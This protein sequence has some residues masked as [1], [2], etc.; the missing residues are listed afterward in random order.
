MNSHLS[1]G[2]L[3][4]LLAWCVLSVGLFSASFPANAGNI[5]LSSAVSVAPAWVV[6]T[7]GYDTATVVFA[8]FNDAG[9]TRTLTGINWSYELYGSIQVNIV[10]TWGDT[11]FSISSQEVGFSIMRPAT[12]SDVSATVHMG[13]ATTYPSDLNLSCADGNSCS[14]ANLIT[15]VGGGSTS[16]LSDLTFLA[17]GPQM[18]FDWY[19]GTWLNNDPDWAGAG[20]DAS[21]FGTASIEYVYDEATAVP[22][23]ATF[24]LV[25]L[26][27][28]G[29]GA[30]R[31]T[32]R[33]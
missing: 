10:N 13:G 14:K 8:P 18:E 28:V 25:G 27:L 19:Y 17:G 3:Q 32:T 22:E 21:L 2:F 20:I 11:D 9:G 1:D 12:D 31:R 24:L 33:L 4:R 23:P 5:V 15:F 7:H 16:I 26:G 29:L 6:D 30:I